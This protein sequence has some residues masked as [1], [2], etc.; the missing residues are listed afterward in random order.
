MFTP[1]VIGL[2]MLLG[3]FCVGTLI[4]LFYGVRTAANQNA[5]NHLA[6]LQGIKLPGEES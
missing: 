5:L 4:I 1:I 6:K 3:T 2:L